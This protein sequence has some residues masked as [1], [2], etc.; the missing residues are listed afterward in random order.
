MTGTEY[1]YLSEGDI[2]KVTSD[3]DGLAEKGDLI[4]VVYRNRFKE[5]VYFKK[6]DEVIGFSVTSILSCMEI[7]KKH[8]KDFIQTTFLHKFDVGDTVYLMVDNKVVSKK[9]LSISYSGD[10]HV[11]YYF[12]GMMYSGDEGLF[13]S[14]EELL[15]SL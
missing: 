13:R 1:L 14:K 8:G 5:I 11:T 9:V 7:Y 15:K 12:K 6:S 10:K 3:L 2:C 4:E